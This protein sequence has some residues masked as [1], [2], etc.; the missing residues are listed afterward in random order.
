M[1]AGGRDSD[2]GGSSSVIIRVT[3]VVPA[4]KS[5]TRVWRASRVCALI[6]TRETDSIVPRCV[7]RYTYSIGIRSVFTREREGSSA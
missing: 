7:R 5:G 6:R 4:S 2:G 3:R 1:V